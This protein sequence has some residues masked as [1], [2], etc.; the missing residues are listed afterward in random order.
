M[1]L[2]LEYAINSNNNFDRIIY[3]TDSES[4]QLRYSRSCQNSLSVL[5]QKNPNIWCHTVDLEGYGTTQFTGKNTNFLSGWNENIISYI[6][7]T[8]QG[9]DSMI[10]HIINIP[11]DNNN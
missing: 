11:L 7:K 3:F 5:R 1:I 9:I 4:N 8:E 2:P 10:N 6:K